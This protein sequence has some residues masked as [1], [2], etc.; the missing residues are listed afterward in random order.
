MGCGG[1]VGL[2]VSVVAPEKERK[3]ICVMGWVSSLGNIDLP[4][5]GP[6]GARA[7]LLSTVWAVFWASTQPSTPDTT[8][9]PGLYFTDLSPTICYLITSYSTIFLTFYI[10]LF[11]NKS[12]K[13]YKYLYVF[14]WILFNSNFLILCIRSISSNL[15]AKV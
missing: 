15:G 2:D 9:P 8:H 11:F 4:C 3:Y 6:T 12:T 5:Y 7:G 10:L 13:L 14:I 1:R